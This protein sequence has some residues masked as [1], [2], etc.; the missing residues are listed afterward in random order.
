MIVIT[1]I[2][3]LNDNHSHDIKGTTPTSPMPTSMTST[4]GAETDGKDQVKIYLLI[5]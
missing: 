2:K 5:F 1:N 3:I 4:S